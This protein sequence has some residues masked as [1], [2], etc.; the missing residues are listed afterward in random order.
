MTYPTLVEAFIKG[1][2][3]QNLYIDFEPVSISGKA[4][5]KSPYDLGFTPTGIMGRMKVNHTEGVA[6]G[7][8]AQID[9]KDGAAY[10]D[11]SAYQGL[12]VK[13]TAYVQSEDDVVIMGLSYDGKTEEYTNVATKNEE[14]K[15]MGFAIELPKASDLSIYFKGNDGVKY[16]IDDVSIEIVDS[17]DGITFEFNDTVSENKDTTAGTETSVSASTE[18]STASSVSASVSSSTTSTTTNVNQEEKMKTIMWVGT[19][20]FV[21]AVVVMIAAFILSKYSRREDD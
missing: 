11:I 5:V 21:L 13:I 8:S 10:L 1:T 16:Y 17:L 7:Y 12:K 14:W 20:I 6:M 2:P 3:L 15:G 19:G 9:T 18:T 4:T